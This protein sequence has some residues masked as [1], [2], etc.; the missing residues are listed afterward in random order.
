MGEESEKGKKR[1]SERERESE[2]RS[3][4]CATLQIDPVHV[5]NCGRNGHQGKNP[6]Q[7]IKKLERVC[8]HTSTHQVGVHTAKECDEA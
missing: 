5:L 2:C 1:E 8:S 6:E 7:E 4:A 3:M